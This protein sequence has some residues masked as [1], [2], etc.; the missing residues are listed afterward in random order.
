MENNETN[1]GIT[2]TYLNKI[3]ALCQSIY[4]LN[5]SNFIDIFEFP[6]VL[7]FF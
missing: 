7:H 2:A 6:H 5:K 1:I 4:F 3:S